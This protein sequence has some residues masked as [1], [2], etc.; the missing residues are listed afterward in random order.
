MIDARITG[1]ISMGKSIPHAVMFRAKQ[2]NTF[3]NPAYLSA[4]QAGRYTG[5]LSATLAS[6]WEQDGEIIFPRGYGRRLHDLAT[7]SGAEIAWQDLRT[8]APVTFP[9]ALDGINLRQYQENVLEAACDA[10]QGVIISPTGSGKTLTALE[11]IR[12]RGQRAIILVH[13]NALA[14]QWV[15]VIRQRLKIIAGRIG[16]GM[17][18][19][20]NHITVATIQTLYLRQDAAMEIAKNIGTVVVDECHHMP[21][22]TFAVV[23]G[24]FSAKYRYGFT[25]TPKRKD[26]LEVMV[27][28][29]IGEKLA[30]VSDQDVLDTGGIVPVR[31][32]VMDTGCTFPMVNAA[33]RD[34]S[35][36]LTAVET[37]GPRNVMLAQ[38]A[39]RMSATRQVLILTDRVAHAEIISV[40]IPG[41]ILAHGGLKTAEKKLA[42]AQMNTAKVTVGTKGLLGEGLDCSAWA[43]LIIASPISG[44]TPI[45]QAVGRVIRGS[46]GKK[47]GLVIDMVDP[48]PYGHGSFRKRRAVY[49]RRGWPVM[50]YPT[51]GLKINGK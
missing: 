47:D 19:L 26:G 11:L 13:S 45:Q 35:K 39:I 29:L 5:K 37:D 9:A 14:A 42:L 20:G 1:V 36:F 8:E 44:E 22:D 28:R 41:A 33:D 21:A 30:Q 6:W 48:H 23:I 2:D 40:L 25:A 16:D 15:S 24:L 3:R 49:N 50:P 18:V 12:R 17:W 38:I 7:N 34:W 46:P 31:V 51:D 4:L 10:T 32:M 27:Y 43:C